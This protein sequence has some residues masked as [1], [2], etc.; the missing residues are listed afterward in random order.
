MGMKNL[1]WLNL[2]MLVMFIIIDGVR[3]T[4][5]SRFS[6]GIIIALVIMNMCISNDMKEYLISS[7]MLVVSTVTGMILFTYY[8]YNFVSSDFETPIV[9]AF[10][11][12]VYGMISLAV[13][14]VGAVVVVIKDRTKLK[15][16]K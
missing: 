6:I 3:G 2:I 1:K 11:M 5:I 16:K 13:A 14:A 8:Y 12:M 4:V 15:Q 10:M 7:A 9:G